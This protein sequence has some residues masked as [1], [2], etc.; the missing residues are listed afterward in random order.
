M[1]QRTDHRSR[2]IT[3]SKSE[4]K[5]EEEKKEKRKAT[6]FLTKAFQFTH[7]DSNITTTHTRAPNEIITALYSAPVPR[8]QDPVTFFL[9]PG[10]GHTA[11][12]TQ[13]HPVIT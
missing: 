11:D 3:A 6:N 1:P 4:E 9:L 7:Y 13:E 12:H 8:R 5:K 10:H 2:S